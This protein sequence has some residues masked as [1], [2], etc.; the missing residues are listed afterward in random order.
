MTS[1]C[2]PSPEWI[3]NMWTK[4]GDVALYPTPDYNRSVNKNALADFWIEDGSFVRLQSLKLS[5]SLP[6][7]IAKL[8]KMREL[9]VS[10]YG[11]NL[12]TWTNYSGFDPEFGGSTLAEGIDNGKYPRRRE[13][14]FNINFGF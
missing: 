5:Y 14:G 4:P 9:V 12:L 1:K 2:A 6:S 7:K 8:L 10:L 13:F 3:E 11:N